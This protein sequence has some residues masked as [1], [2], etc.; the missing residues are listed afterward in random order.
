[1][2][3]YNYPHHYRKNIFEAINKRFHAEFFFGCNGYT[4][5]KF[6]K[7][8]VNFPFECAI[9]LYVGKFYYQ[10]GT[11]RF[12]RKSKGSIIMLNSPYCLSMYVALIYARLSRRN[13]F[14]WSHG[15][16]DQNR[17]SWFKVL[18]YSRFTG[19]LLYSDW[20]K[21]ILKAKGVESSK[22][23]VIKNSLYRAESAQIATCQKSWD[24]VFIGRL[25]PGKRLDMLLKAMYLIKQKK[26]DVSLLVIGEGSH[27]I[28][29][30]E[31]ANDL[32][33]NKSISWVGAVYEEK[34][35]KSLLSQCKF[36][37]SPGNVGLTAIES[38]SCGVP[39]ITHCDMNKQMPEAEAVV[40]EKTGFKFEH[41]SIPDLQRAMEKALRASGYS[42][43]SKQSIN[44]VRKNWSVEAQIYRLERAIC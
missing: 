20:S 13:V 26:K 37:V 27:G 36:C 5:K 11:L 12:L 15:I 10:L 6:E 30:R 41:N 28:R 3:L 2:I 24:F 9:N 29:L 22:L 21:Q 44:E 17:S 38:L 42:Q 14:L 39:V 34:E 19:I 7:N 25:E 23:F 1:M 8:D 31:L 33:L 35:K 43:L 16:L 40:E 18:L 32:G 4:I